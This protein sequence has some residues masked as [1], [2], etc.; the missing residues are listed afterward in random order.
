MAKEWLL[1]SATN[2]FQFN[3]KRNVGAVSEAIRK[4]APKN[5]E[6]WENYY[7]QNI[8]SRE[9]IEE[10]GRRLYIKI[11]EVLAAEIDSINENDCIDYIYN[12]V[13][14]RT[15]DGY[16]TEIKTV[17]GQ[18]EKILEQRIEPAPDEWDRLFN[19]DFYIDIDGKYIGLQIKPASDVSHITQIYKERE[20]QKLTHIKFSKKY[21][22]KVFYVISIKKDGSKEIQNIEVIDD[23]KSEI[24]RLQNLV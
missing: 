16:L 22:G 11:T 8:K 1:N 13:I 7:F 10:L 3:F 9:H 18:L 4:C 12:L 19:V 6:E 23:I 24:R 5:L 17:Y 20:L 2:R 14:N 15:Y 21:Q